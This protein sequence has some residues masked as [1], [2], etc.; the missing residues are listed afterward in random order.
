M[1]DLKKRMYQLRSQG[2]KYRE[3]AA[4]LGVSMGSVCEAIGHTGARFHTI[5]EKSCIYPGL[6]EWLNKTRTS[7]TLLTR[8]IYGQYGSVYYAQVRDNLTGKRE[9]K[10]YEIDDLLRIT[11]MTYEEL[12]YGGK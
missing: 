9:M 10:K 11:G 12:F 1:S 7:K 5:N 3:I 8:L 2:Y 6:R 4:E